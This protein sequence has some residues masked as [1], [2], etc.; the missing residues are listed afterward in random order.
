[1]MESWWK[2]ILLLSVT[3]AVNSLSLPQELNS[4]RDAEYI[5][6]AV[7]IYN[8][9]ENA[10]YIFKPLNDDPDSFLQVDENV[11]QLVF[12]IKE[13]VCPKSENYN[14]VECDFK[15]DGEVKVC[16][17]YL[18]ELKNEDYI[19]CSPLS[20]H[21]HEKQSRKKRPCK[22]CTLLPGSLSHIHRES[23]F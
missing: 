17:T 20:Q 5:K 2:A 10:N 4:I 14:I 8:K 18:T 3:T 15:H 11:Q 21:S 16:N 12:K 23:I 9:K 6:R 19:M 22:K 7:E 13:T 1:M